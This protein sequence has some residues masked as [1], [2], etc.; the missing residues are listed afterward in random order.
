MT[1][2]IFNN[3]FQCTKYTFSSFSIVSI[4]QLSNGIFQ[5]VELDIST[6]KFKNCQDR[7]FNCQIRH[8]KTIES[9]DFTFCYYM[10]LKFESSTL[11]ILNVDIWITQNSYHCNPNISGMNNHLR[12]IVSYGKKFVHTNDEW[13]WT[14][15]FWTKLLVLLFCH[16]SYVVL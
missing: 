3:L 11:M 14:G 15:L 5:T 2:D 12:F 9:L 4:A 13:K 8:L 1:I 16:P 6:V 7:Q 10:N